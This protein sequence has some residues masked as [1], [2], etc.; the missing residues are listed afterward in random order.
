MTLPESRAREP[1]FTPEQLAGV[2]V[3]RWYAR[4][5]ANEFIGYLR[6]NALF[7]SLKYTHELPK[8]AVRVVDPNDLYAPPRIRFAGEWR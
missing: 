4:D 3:S 6:P 7:G 1:S 2:F 5:V 8:G